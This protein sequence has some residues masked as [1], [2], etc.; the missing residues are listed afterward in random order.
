MSRPPINAARNYLPPALPSNPTYRKLNPADAP[1]MIL[2]MTSDAITQDQMYDAADSI[3]GQKCPQVDGVG[4]V[5]VWGSSQPAVRI[6]ANPQML[7]N[8]GVGVETLRT[9][10]AAQN[11][12][13]AK[14]S[15][16][17][18]GKMWMIR[19]NDQLM[20]AK[21]YRNLVIAYQATARRSAAQRRGRRSGLV[22]QHLQRGQL[23]RQAQRA[24]R[25][26]PPAGALVIA[27]AD[28][29]ISRRCRSC[30]AS[31]PPA[32]NLDL[33]STAPPRPAFRVMTFSARCSL[34]SPLVVLV[35]LFFCRE[36]VS[37]DSR[38]LPRAWLSS[39]LSA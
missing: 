1:V 31:L 2:V 19:A 16:N 4:Q 29:V 32:I 24:D 34:L 10:V 35:V 23:Q 26:F 39:A 15:L 30:K 12:N 21:D 28:G 13:Q 5:F 22:F 14:G 20:K 6:E 33:A 17:D 36:C 9:A 8:M 37:F 18:A 11:A 38:A 25:D 7:N 3:M 27:T